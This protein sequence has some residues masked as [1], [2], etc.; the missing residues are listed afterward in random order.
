[1]RSDLVRVISTPDEL[2]AE[3]VVVLFG[4]GQGEGEVCWRTVGRL[5]WNGMGMWRLDETVL[6]G[7]GRLGMFRI[8]AAGKMRGRA[9]CSFERRV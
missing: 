4:V 2:D 8:P 3:S 5:G 6:T 1:M 9:E 7:G